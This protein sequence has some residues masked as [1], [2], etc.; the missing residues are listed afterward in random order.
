VPPIKTGEAG[1]PPLRFTI[2]RLTDSKLLKGSLA[3]RV[4]VQGTVKGKKVDQVS[5]AAYQRRGDVLSGVYSFGS[6]TPEQLAFFLHAARES[7]KNLRNGSAP[8]SAPTA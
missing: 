8:P 2:T 3:V 1:L 4:R 5:Y 6:D 7:A